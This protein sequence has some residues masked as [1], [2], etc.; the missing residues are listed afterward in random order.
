[1]SF[2]VD[3][4][5]SS[6]SSNHIGQEATD[7]AALQAQLAQT[8]YHCQTS[9]HRRATHACTPMAC[10]PTSSS[11]WERPELDRRRSNSV[12]SKRDMEEQRETVDAMDEDE[13]MVEDMLFPSVASALDATYP[14]SHMPPPP[15]PTLYPRHSHSRK[16][17]ASASSFSSMHYDVPSAGSSLFA[18]TDPF[19]LAQM[20][21]QQ[22]SP[23]PSF[24]SQFGKPTQQSPFLKGHPF[25]H[26]QNVSEVHPSTAFVR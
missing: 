8:L 4:L 13:L 1:M 22:N 25:A 21:A 19:Y 17:S 3:D 24:F 16:S 18:T 26:R 7:L 20:A 6:M 2:S 9:E 10:T 12:V 5:V 15:S 23:A 11:L 14:A